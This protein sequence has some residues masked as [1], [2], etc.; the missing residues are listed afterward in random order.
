MNIETI[1]QEVDKIIAMSSDDEAAHGSE[2]SLHLQLINYYCPA[3][4]VAEIKR[5]SEADFARWCA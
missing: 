1:K 3:D 5:L 4:V 2:D